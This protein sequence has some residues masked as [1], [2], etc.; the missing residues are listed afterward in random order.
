S[1][2][3]GF[4]FQIVII[5]FFLLLFGEIIP[6]VLATHYPEKF[7]VFTASPLFILEKIFRPL[8]SIL[9][10]STSF[11]DKKFQSKQ[12][13]SMQDISKA[14]DITSN[15]ITE[16]KELLKGIA[17]FG[18]IDVNEIMK[19]RVDVVAVDIKTDFKKL[20]SII[21][22]SGFSRIPVYSKT[23]DDI[24]GVLYIKDLLA[25]IN[26]PATFKWQSLIRPPYFIPEKKKINDLL[27]EIQVKKVHIAIVVDEYGGTSGIVTLENILEEIVGEISD[28][29]E[30]EEINYTK[31]DDNNFIF[32][33]KTLLNDFYK[34]TST[35]NTIFD[36]V[37]GEADTLA[38][39]ILEL[40]G[41]IPKLYEEMAYK[42]FTLKIE[43]AD[44]RRIKKIKITI[45]KK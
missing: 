2:I 20:I 28:E 1:P 8:S 16:D 7:V 44:N 3:L 11:F 41:E 18:N 42:N 13:I 21:I 36:D 17:D 6:K 34:I 15:S 43:D 19:P 31:I 5:T 39:L 29:S 38:G 4:V 22:D 33:G 45:N 24:K 40:K 27:E 26:K 23:F 25:H 37:K 32:E 9:I 14:L 12:N 35:E 10:S 30:E